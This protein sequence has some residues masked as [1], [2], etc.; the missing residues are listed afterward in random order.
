MICLIVGSTHRSLLGPTMNAK[1][2]SYTSFALKKSY[3][4]K[5]KNKKHLLD[6]TYPSRVSVFLE[7]SENMFLF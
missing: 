3:I 7:A 4:N 2:E 1:R 5:K 6:V